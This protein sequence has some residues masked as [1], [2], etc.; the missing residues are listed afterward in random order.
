MLY[1]ITPEEEKAALHQVI[2]NGMFNESQETLNKYNSLSQLLNGLSADSDRKYI[3]AATLEKLFIKTFL[4]NNTAYYNLKN[5]FAKYGN[6]SLVGKIS[7]LSITAND[8]KNLISTKDTWNNPYLFVNSLPFSFINDVTDRDQLFEKI[9][10]IDS[11]QWDSNYACYP[12]ILTL[13]HYKFSD[14]QYKVMI[15]FASSAWEPGYLT[16]FAACPQTKHLVTKEDFADEWFM[17]LDERAHCDEPT[18]NNYEY[19]LAEA[20]RELFCEEFVS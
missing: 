3:V 12:Q 16:L 5:H 2:S 20:Y 1:T 8:F 13:N 17:I 9:M 6:E 10:M 15:Q 14:E 19:E 18:F 7:G 4:N 11:L